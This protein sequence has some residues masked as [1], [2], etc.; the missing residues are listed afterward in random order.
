MDI[1][2]ICVNAL[3]E[4]KGENIVAIDIS[5]ISIMADYLVIASGSNKNQIQAMSDNVIE[6]LH[7]NDIVQK[8]IEGYDASNWIL[9]DIGDVVVHIFDKESR[10]FYDLER[11]YIDGKKL[12]L[13]TF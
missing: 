1:L 2:D 3:S 10:G 12:D 11:L 4:K 8:N 13:N 6:C 9:I 7:K 5:S